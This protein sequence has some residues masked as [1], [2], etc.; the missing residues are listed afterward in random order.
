LPPKLETGRVCAVCG[1]RTS[2]NGRKDTYG[3]RN[4][5]VRNGIKGDKA[6]PDCVQALGK[7]RLG[8]RPAP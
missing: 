8:R 1:E 7:K 6:H 5:L 3:F 4:T 2:P